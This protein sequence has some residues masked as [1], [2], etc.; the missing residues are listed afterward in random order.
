M[1]VFRK[2]G[3]ALKPFR[4]T[5]ERSLA[6]ESA[7]EDVDEDVALR[8]DVHPGDHGMFHAKG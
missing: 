2:K 6:F 1:G 3:G 4:G 7:V 8:Q 5:V